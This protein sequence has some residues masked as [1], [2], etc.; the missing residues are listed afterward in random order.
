[1]RSENGLATALAEVVQKTVAA[2]QTSIIEG[3]AKR[4]KAPM[5]VVEWVDSGLIQGLPASEHF[6]VSIIY[7]QQLVRIT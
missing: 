5:T 2:K 1:M 3:V 4:M 6:N 7:K